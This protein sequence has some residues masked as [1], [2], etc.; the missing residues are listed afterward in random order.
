MAKPEIFSGGQGKENK[1]L[2]YKKMTKI[3]KSNKCKTMFE[4]SNLTQT[5]LAVLH[6]YNTCLSYK[7]QEDKV[8]NC[9]K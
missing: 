3:V 5:V 9:K 6:I 4:F 7:L 2:M 8:T 1:V